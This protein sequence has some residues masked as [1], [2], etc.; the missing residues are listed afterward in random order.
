MNDPLTRTCTVAALHRAT[1]RAAAIG[2]PTDAERMAALR[3]A[4]K[5]TE[6]LRRLER[7]CKTHAGIG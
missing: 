7:A 5:R 3:C 4:R 1:I 6:A 2:K